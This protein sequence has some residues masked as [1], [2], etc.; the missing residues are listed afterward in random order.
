MEKRQRIVVISED[1]AEPWDEGIKKFTYSVARAMERRHDVRMVNVDRSGLGGKT[2]VRVPG[3]RTFFSRALF[4]EVRSF[5][6][7]IVLYVP[8]PSNTLAS[9]LRSA[10]L[11]RCAP[12]ARHGMVA[13]IPRTHATRRK[14]F[15]KWAAPDIIWVPSYRSLLRLSRLGLCGDVLP[16]GVDLDAFTPAG[17]EEKRSLREYYHIDPEAF[18]AL[19][20]GH[21]S[22][23]RNLGVLGSLRELAGPDGVT[24]LLVGSTSTPEDKVLRSELEASG[25]RVI[26]EVVKV[27]EFYRL[28]DCYVFPVEDSEG[29]VEMPLS[30][31][32]SLASGLPVVTTPFGGLRD[33]L[34]DGDDV[35]YWNTRDELGEAVRDL[36]ERGAPRIRDMKEFSWDRI[37]GTIVDGLSE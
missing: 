28:A 3:T 26:R 33:F 32:E 13:L 35:R 1:L 30:V 6:P 22:S 2:A 27:E 15:L 23:K 37:A 9:F 31:V 11:K 7:D 10:A 4:R 25:V 34:P 12:G 36:K 14:P 17:G 29:S 24:V 21:L 8:S 16:V 18:V 5:R 19:H 20:I